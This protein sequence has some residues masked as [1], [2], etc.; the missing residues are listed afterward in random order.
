MF[1]N[2][3]VIFRTR[4]VDGV[5]AVTRTVVGGKSRNNNQVAHEEEE[6]ELAPKKKGKTSSRSAK[7]E[8]AAI[9]A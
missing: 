5:S 9:L 2:A 3:N 4:F 6:E 1:N 7:G 8:N